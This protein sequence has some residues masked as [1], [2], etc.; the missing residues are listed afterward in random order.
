[1]RKE[2]F[3]HILSGA[4]GLINSVVHTD[5][6]FLVIV[7]YSSP[8]SSAWEDANALMAGSGVMARI[9]VFLILLDGHD[10]KVLPRIIGSASVDMVNMPSGPFAS[11]V[12]PREPMCVVIAPINSDANVTIPVRGASNISG[13]NT[14]TGRIATDAP[15]ENTCFRVVRQKLSELFCCKIRLSHDALQRLIGQGLAAT[16]N[17][18]PAPLLYGSLA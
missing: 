16:A 8:P 12:Q 18:C 15:R 2:L 1:M 10:P 5:M 14:P 3:L 17:R 6:Y 13:A 7:S 4:D 9:A 11:H